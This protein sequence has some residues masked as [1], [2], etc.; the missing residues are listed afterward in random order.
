MGSKTLI[1]IHPLHR[2]NAGGVFYVQKES[3]LR[4]RADGVWFRFAGGHMAGVRFCLLLHRYG[5]YFVG[6]LV[7]G[8]KISVI[9]LS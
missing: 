7:Y 4:L 8:Q 3:A 2:I 9:N 5:D 6:F 1:C